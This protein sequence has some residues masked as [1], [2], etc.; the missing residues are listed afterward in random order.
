MKKMLEKG[1][2][3]YESFGGHEEVLD[4]INRVFDLIFG[5][6]NLSELTT[7]Y[8]K[9]HHTLMGQGLFEIRVHGKNYSPEFDWRRKGLGR[10]IEKMLR[11]NGEVPMDFAGI[12]SKTDDDKHTAHIMKQ[13]TKR[14]MNSKDVSLRPAPS[15]NFPM[16][17]RGTEEYRRMITR[18][19]YA[20]DY[21]VVN[22]DQKPD[23]RKDGGYQHAKVTFLFDGMPVEFRAMTK[24]VDRRAKIGDI[25]HLDF[26]SPEPLVMDDITVLRTTNERAKHIGDTSLYDPTVASADALLKEAISAF[27]AYQSSR[28]TPSRSS[29]KKSRGKRG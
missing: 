23:E 6:T 26:I 5:K 20:S 11:F 4:K 19:L 29:S 9:I 1:R 21:P 16:H 27:K 24:D 3:K 13:V 12:N 18:E 14:L 28:T 10:F 7:N 15:R 25:N 2:N 8:D 17:V 22:I